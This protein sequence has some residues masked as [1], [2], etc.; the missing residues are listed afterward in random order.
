MRRRLLVTAL[1]FV[2]LAS[3]GPTSSTPAS[4]IAIGQA[5]IDLL[6][7]TGA[8]PPPGLLRAVSAA[9]PTLLPPAQ[10]PPLLDQLTIATNL[11]NT[12]SITTPP[13]QAAST[14]RRVEGYINTAMAVFGQASGTV[15]ALAPYTAL[16]D[17]AT[18]GVQIVE[19]FIN[20]QFPAARLAA[21]DPSI[22]RLRALAAAHGMTQAAATRLL[23]VKA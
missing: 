21:A 10:V 11:L 1:P 17:A 5:T 4:V 7:G 13:L 6:A 19:T 2:L 8:T 18:V 9:D 22:A 14:L 12:V 15:S 20:Q 3:C 23:G 16:I